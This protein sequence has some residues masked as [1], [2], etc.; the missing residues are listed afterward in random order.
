MR[1]RPPTHPPTYSPTHTHTRTD[2]LECATNKG[3]CSDTCVETDGSFY[4]ECP[5]GYKLKA[6][7]LTCESM[8]LC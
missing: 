4:C 8:R 6:N 2:I 3:G 7:N 1:K 5:T